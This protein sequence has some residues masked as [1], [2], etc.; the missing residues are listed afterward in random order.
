MYT[1]QRAIG[2]AR[3]TN[4]SWQEIDLTNLH[5]SSLWATYRDVYAVLT[6]PAEIEELSFRL[7]DKSVELS[8]FDGTL[9]QY[10]ASLGDGSLPTERGV[11]VINRAH[12]VYGDVLMTEFIP[13]TSNYLL[14]DGVEL[15]N[16]DKPHAT[17]TTPE[18]YDTDYREMRDN[19]LVNVNGF[20]HFTD[21]NSKGLHVVEANK[22]RTRS[23]KNFMGFYNFGPIG[24]LD[25]AKITPE[26][27]AFEKDQDDVVGRVYVKT[28]LDFSETT[29]ALVLGGYLILQQDEVLDIVSPGV[30]SLR[31][32]RYPLLER[33]HESQPFFDFSEFGQTYDPD[34]P[35][36]VVEN[37][38]YSETFLTKYFTMSQSF[39]VNIEA[40]GILTE[41]KYPERDGVPNTFMYYERPKYPLV[42][43]CGR[44]DPYWVQEEA[45]VFQIRCMDSV[46]STQMHLKA[47]RNS[48]PIAD[49]S[50]YPGRAQRAGYGYF[51][52]LVKERIEI[53]V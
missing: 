35:T 8:L 42:V 16:E 40:Q 38:L 49:N 14:G 36:K 13:Q 23:G 52:S 6:H 32:L 3:Q 53:V 25:Y 45:G 51:L 34:D 4:A 24:K 37:E 43:G 2:L 30:L 48:R 39:I 28:G 7:T 46:K 10:L 20:Y 44:H 9:P 41:R 12:A 47:P 17:L 27:L 50:L 29:P 1:Y 5:L 21:A 15:G 18:S 31:M 11:P 33:Y 19:C 26:M 22:T